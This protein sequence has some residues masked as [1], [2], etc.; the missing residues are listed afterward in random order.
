MGSIESTF[1]STRVQLHLYN[2]VTGAVSCVSNLF[3]I[4]TIDLLCVAHIR[5]VKCGMK[6][7][8]GY[9]W[10]DVERWTIP[11][12]RFLRNILSS[13]VWRFRMRILDL[14]PS[15]KPLNHAIR[16]TTL[17]TFLLRLMRIHARKHNGNRP[18]AKW[19]S[20]SF[21]MQLPNLN[22]NSIPN[23]SFE[24]TAPHSIIIARKCRLTEAQ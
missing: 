14:G 16:K 4:D 21:A 10:A 19:K 24:P 8:F 11:F 5:V 23:W 9:S 17:S 12:M 20:A 1:F 22:K 18:S 3:I 13:V 6:T 7:L 15:T 2:F